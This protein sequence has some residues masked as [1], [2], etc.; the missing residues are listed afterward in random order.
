MMYIFSCEL[1]GRKTVKTQVRVDTN[2]FQMIQKVHALCSGCRL[3]MQMDV[4]VYR[5]TNAG[6]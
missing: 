1:Y 2:R 5:L 6:R 4:I 3:D